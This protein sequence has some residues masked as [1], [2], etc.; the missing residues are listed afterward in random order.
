M[1]KMVINE[2]ASSAKKAF[3][4]LQSIDDR[5]KKTEGLERLKRA[6]VERKEEILT[7]NDL[8]VQLITRT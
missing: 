7:A 8:D 1:K 3:D 4:E 6:L 2:V 5:N